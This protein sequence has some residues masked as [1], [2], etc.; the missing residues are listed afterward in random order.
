MQVRPPA[1]RLTD[2]R[3]EEA[4]ALYGGPAEGNA[5]VVQR[6]LAERGC[7]ASVRTVQ[8]AVARHAPG[9]ARRATLAT[10]RVE[11]AP[12]DQLQIDFGEKRVHDRRHARPRL[13]ARRGPQLFAPPLRE[14]VSQ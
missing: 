11:T 13:S 9:A 7:T 4:R 6:L 5:V 10:V 1:R 12:G 3:R 14:S 8:R 2:E